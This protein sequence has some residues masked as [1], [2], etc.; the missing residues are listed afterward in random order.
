MKGKGNE[1]QNSKATYL[2]RPSET[3][4]EIGIKMIRFSDS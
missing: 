3:M 2:S 4:A 1:A